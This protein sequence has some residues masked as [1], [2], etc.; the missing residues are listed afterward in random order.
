MK[1]VPLPSPG[2]DVVPKYSEQQQLEGKPG[3]HKQQ[4]WI[5]AQ[6][7]LSPFLEEVTAAQEMEKEGTESCSLHLHECS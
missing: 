7:K 4:G 1:Q 6:P 3:E 2:Q 5:S